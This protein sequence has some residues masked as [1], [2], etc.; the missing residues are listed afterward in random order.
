MTY[1]RVMAHIAIDDREHA[2]AALLAPHVTKRRLL[3]AD[4]LITGSD[5]EVVFAIERKTVA[6]LS[7]SLRDGRFAEQRARLVETYGR[8][9][10]V[11]VLEGREGVWSM[12]KERGAL[13]A[14]H[15]RDRLQVLRTLDVAET[16]DAVRKLVELCEEGRADARDA[17][18]QVDVHPARRLCTSTPRAALAAMLCV[19]PGMS[20]AKARAVAEGAGGMRALCESVHIDRVGAVLKLRETVCAGRRL[21]PVCAARI[22]DALADG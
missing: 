13:M 7:A 21:G 20:V 9:R 1:A 2:L 14:L 18:P 8:E 11:Y 16:A 5:G 6:D 17:P 10:V 19:L 3:L 22:A 4:I 15:F 12:P